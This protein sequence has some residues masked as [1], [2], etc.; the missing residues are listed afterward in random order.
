MVCTVAWIL[1]SFHK[2]RKL[3]FFGYSRLGRIELTIRV[4]VLARLFA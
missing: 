2:V 3:V 1:Y 4:Q